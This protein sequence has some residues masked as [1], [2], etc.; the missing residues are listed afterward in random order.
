VIPVLTE[1]LS[2]EVTTDPPPLRMHTLQ[3]RAL[4]WGVDVQHIIAIDAELERVH[5]QDDTPAFS[6]VAP[7]GARHLPQKVLVSKTFS[8]REP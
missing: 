2:P 7:L 3:S 4:A 8:S 6:R 1:K 5:N